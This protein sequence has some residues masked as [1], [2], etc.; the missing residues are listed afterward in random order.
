MFSTPVPK[1]RPIEAVGCTLGPLRHL[2]SVA[3]R[4]RGGSSI[5][6]CLAYVARVATSNHEARLSV[7][8]KLGR[9][10]PWYGLFVAF[11][12]LSATCIAVFFFI[13][14]HLPP[15]PRLCCPSSGALVAHTLV[16]PF[17][18]VPLVVLFVGRAE[19]LGGVESFDYIPTF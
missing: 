2:P 1:G 17:V 12:I 5:R 19:H 13:R 9:R 16:S 7:R 10:E 4:N 6:P 18:R 3:R 14:A 11:S 8:P 15:R